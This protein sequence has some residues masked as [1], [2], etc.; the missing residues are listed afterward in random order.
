MGGRDYGMQ[1]TGL[2]DSGFRDFG[3][4]GFRDFGITYYEYVELVVWWVRFNI[5]TVA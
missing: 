3:I 1:E 2:R 5:V 4:S